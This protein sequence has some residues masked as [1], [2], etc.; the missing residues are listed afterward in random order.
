[1]VIAV[2]I[3]QKSMWNFIRIDSMMT[4]MDD[5]LGICSC[6][7]IARRGPPLDRPGSKIALRPTKWFGKACISG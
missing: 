7:R 6:R 4:T 1:M 3:S 2:D 5:A